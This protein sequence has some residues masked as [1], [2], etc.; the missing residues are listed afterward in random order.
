MP[1]YHYQLLVLRFGEEGVL[2]GKT[3][4]PERQMELQKS[5]VLGRTYELGK[6]C[7]LSEVQVSVRSLALFLFAYN[8]ST[9]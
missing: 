5:G 6:P 7:E 1:L 8:T 2:T 3:V 9:Y 4:V